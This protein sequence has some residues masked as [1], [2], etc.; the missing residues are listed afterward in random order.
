MN[1]PF[2]SLRNKTEDIERALARGN[3]TLARLAAYELGVRLSHTLTALRELAESRSAGGQASSE[4]Q[5]IERVL[6]R[7]GAKLD[8]SIGFLEAQ[9]LR[10]AA[11]AMHSMLRLLDDLD[12][13]ALGAE[14]G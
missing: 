4:E 6:S 11:E 14:A 1:C 2:W 13:N 9:Q 7:F 10:L 12:R 3:S 8:R 5:A